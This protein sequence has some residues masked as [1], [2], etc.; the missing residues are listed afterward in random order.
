MIKLTPE[1]AVQKLLWIMEVQAHINDCCETLPNDPECMAVA[2]ELQD[3]VDEEWK[4]LR[5]L[6]GDRPKPHS[7]LSGRSRHPE[8][9]AS[10]R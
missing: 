8:P 1:L 10:A 9:G 7:T 5:P 4:S 2:S 6:I 3:R